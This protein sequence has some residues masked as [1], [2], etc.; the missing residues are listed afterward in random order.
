[1]SFACCAPS[2][3]P[4]LFN[5]AMAR[6][7]HESRV[8]LPACVGPQH[9]G[10]AVRL[11]PEPVG[12]H[13]CACTPVVEGPRDDRS[14]RVARL[15]PDPRRPGG[16]GSRIGARCSGGGG[17]PSRTPPPAACPCASA[18]RCGSCGSAGP[19]R[20]TRASC[21]AGGGGGGECAGV[22]RGAL[23]GHDLTS[24]RWHDV[25]AVLDELGGWFGGRQLGR[26]VVGCKLASQATRSKGA[27]G[28]PVAARTIVEPVAADRP[29]PPIVVCPAGLPSS[30]GV[31][32]ARDRRARHSRI[33]GGPS[34]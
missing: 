13:R 3:A 2:P 31:L 1:M 16:T 5:K 30:Q 11:R 33:R 27:G 26:W 10:P 24:H 9:A 25:A 18:G 8:P 17:S 19:G 15:A 7:H 28:R 20:R 23:P 12:R 22:P 4:Q 21:G 6:R 29:P 14:G 34:P 32:L